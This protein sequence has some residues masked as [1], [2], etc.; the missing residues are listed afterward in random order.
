MTFMSRDLTRIVFTRSTYVYT[1]R[2]LCV[3]YMWAA[4]MVDRGQFGARCSND[5]IGK[6]SSYDICFFQDPR[7]TVIFL[8]PKKSLNFSENRVLL[9]RAFKFLCS[10]VRIV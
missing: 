4:Y 6:R 2:I 10:S 7:D 8:H 9:F 3:P 1:F 5:F